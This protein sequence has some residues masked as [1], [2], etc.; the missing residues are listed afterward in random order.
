MNL[1]L[2]RTNLISTSDESVIFS[3]LK[4]NPNLNHALLA[5]SDTTTIL[6]KSDQ[7]VS[8]AL[9]STSGILLTS[10]RASASSS[11]VVDPTTIQEDV[12][13]KTNPADTD[14]FY[15]HG[16]TQ[17]TVQPGDTLS[18]IASNFGISPS[19]IMTENKLTTSSTLRAGAVLTILPTTGITYTIKDGDTMEALIKK[20]KVTE[21]DFLDANNLESFEDLSSGAVVVVPMINVAV[22]Q[23]PRT[24]TFVKS[25]AGKVALRTASAPTDLV[26]SA[27]SFIWPTAVRTITQGYSKRHSG[28]DISNSQKVPIYAASDGFVEISGYQSNGYGNTIVI[29][30][31]NGYKTRY[32]HA[33]T[34]NVSAGDYVKQGQEIAKQGNTG[35]VRGATGI[36]LHFEITKNGAKVNPLSYVRP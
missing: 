32:A 2:N 22:P 6:A 18:T 16:L 24:S 27:V 1:S 31:G 30:H 36:H 4:N 9:A 20:Y 35:R 19:T 21:D 12:I 7:L 14:N 3:F 33:S 10:S 13:V 26:N 5:T 28:L 25:E 11:A 17:Y 8:R 34:L 23:A 29:N 15:R